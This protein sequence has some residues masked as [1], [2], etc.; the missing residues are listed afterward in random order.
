MIGM[1]RNRRDRFTINYIRQQMARILRNEC[2]KLQL[3]SCLN[4]VSQMHSRR[5]SSQRASQAN[6][7]PSSPALVTLIR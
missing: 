6:V 7:V 5:I 1:L 4:R 2:S 3:S